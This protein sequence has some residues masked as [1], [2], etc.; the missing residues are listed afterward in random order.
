MTDS[1]WT[2]ADIDRSLDLRKTVTDMNG[3]IERLRALGARSVAQW[4]AVRTPY[5]LSAAEWILEAESESASP[6]DPVTVFIHG[7][8]WRAYGADDFFFVLDPWREAGQT[9]ASINYA[10]CP[11]V[12]L[13]EIVGQILAALAE[14]AE[15]RPQSPIRLLGHSAGAHLAMMACCPDPW[16]TIG[17]TRTPILEAVLISGLY[18]LDPV[19]R[20][21][22]QDVVRLTD[23]EVERLGPLGLDPDS[24]VRYRV[25]HGSNET[26]LFR[27]Q[28]RALVRHLQR[29]GCTATLHE[30]PGVDHFSVLDPDLTKGVHL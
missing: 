7:G 8:Y 14:I 16:R 28:S 24:A 1:N 19:Q 26:E 23:I 12:T 21:F 15:R 25:I 5:G 29:R 4:S 3:R 2:T 27:G 11:D 20:S 18:D 9:V 6:Q 13:T 30:I 10:L 17:R 22:L